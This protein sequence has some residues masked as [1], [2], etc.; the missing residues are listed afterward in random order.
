MDD[1]A[2]RPPALFAHRIVAS[3]PL[4]LTDWPLRLFQLKPRSALLS[5]LL[6]PTRAWGNKTQSSARDGREK[7][8]LGHGAIPLCALVS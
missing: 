6:S 2:V 8:K 3:S 1:D 4:G 7:K 5:L